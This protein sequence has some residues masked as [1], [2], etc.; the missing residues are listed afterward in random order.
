MILDRLHH[1]SGHAVVATALVLAGCNQTGAPAGTSVAQAGS[2][3]QAPG[4]GGCTG[5]IGR[6]RTVID[7][8]N[9]VGQVNPQVYKQMDA[10]VAR[11]EAACAAGQDAEAQRM[12]SAT[13][14]RY[15]YPA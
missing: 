5:Q 1:L 2:S 7:N 10:D 8:E 11:A 15:G 12:L 6:F 9:R 14:A 13:K 3:V 4:G